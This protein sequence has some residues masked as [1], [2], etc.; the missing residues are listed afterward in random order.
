[1]MGKRG[2]RTGLLAVALGVLLVGLFVV[3][4]QAAFAADSGDSFTGEGL[5]M[6]RIF[7]GPPAGAVSVPPS[8]RLNCTANDIAIAKAVQ[9]TTCDTSGTG[10]VDA[11]TCEEGEFFTLLATFQVNVTANARYDAGF[12]FRTDGGASARGNADTTGKC[13]LSFLTPPPPDNPNV[14]QLDGDTCGDMNAGQNQLV[15]FTIENVLCKEAKDSQGKPLGVVALPNCTSWHS[16]QSTQCDAPTSATDSNVFDFHPDTK[17][18]CVCDDT[19]TIPIGIK[20]PAGSL[21]KSATQADVTFSITVTNTS[22]LLI[23]VTKLVDN[24]V[25]GGTPA[26]NI[27]TAHD[28]LI[29]TTCALQQLKPTGESGDSFTCTYV[30][31][32]NDTGGDL[33]NTVT[34]TL[35][36]NVD[37]SSTTNDVDV[38]GSTTINVDLNK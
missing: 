2:C 8:D 9:P 11:N 37:G 23:D 7:I 32:T 38:T 33:T 20:K 21:T 22:T 24:K 34:A 25:T 27:T 18:K 1:M 5:C 30:V 28:N 19:F 4:A 10:C 13:S 26:G 17:S 15:H 29:S 36:R 6:Q 14:F 3:G 16:N 31:R 12:F 35:H